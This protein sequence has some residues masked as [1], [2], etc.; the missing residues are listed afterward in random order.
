VVVV[1]E[2]LKDSEEVGVGA[3]E[4]VVVVEVVA[5]V[6]DELVEAEG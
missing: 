5:E 3:E 2:C 6:D 1:S 4:A